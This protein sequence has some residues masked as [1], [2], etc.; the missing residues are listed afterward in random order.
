MLK[1]VAHD[2]SGMLRQ[3]YDLVDAIDVI[4]LSGFEPFTQ[5]I[6][7]GERISRARLYSITLSQSRD[8]ESQVTLFFQKGEG[9]DD[10]ATR[11]S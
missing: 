4:A 7:Q 2:A 5:G 3:L 11:R 1:E 9:F 8:F 6:F 10:A